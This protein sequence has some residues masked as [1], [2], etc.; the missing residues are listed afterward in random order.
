MEII[1]RFFRPEAQS[2]FLLGQRGTG[3]STFVHAKFPD[4]LYIDLL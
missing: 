2:F 1:E 3:K 4:A